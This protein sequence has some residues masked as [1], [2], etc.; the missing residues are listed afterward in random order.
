MVKRTLGALVGVAALAGPALAG[1]LTFWTWR[2]EDRTQYAQLFADFNRTN[3]GI[4]I[5]FEAYEPQN[6]Q[7]IVSTALAAGRGPDV[8]HVRAYGGLEQFARAHDRVSREDQRAE[9]T[10]PALGNVYPHYARLLVPLGPLN[11]HG[12]LDVAPG[13]QVREY[14]RPHLGRRDLH[15]GCTEAEPGAF[16][17]VPPV[18]AAGPRDGDRV[19]HRTG[20]RA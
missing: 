15:E 3:P 12:S 5:R 8:I 7:T 20:R 4:N 18:Q 13:S 10:P 16:E 1:D 2:Q 6:Y 19:D 11:V 17:Q 9:E 14:R